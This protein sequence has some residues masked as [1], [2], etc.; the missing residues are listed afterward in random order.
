MFV[1]G[2]HAE[3]VGLAAG[4]G[5][6]GLFSV[7]ADGGE[8]LGDEFAVAKLVEGAAH[9]EGLDEFFVDEVGGNAAGEFFDRAEGAVFLAF[10]NDFVDWSVANA[11]NR[12]EAEANLLWADR[13]EFGEGFVGVG[14]EDF[15]AHFGAFFDFE[16]DAIGVAGVGA[17][18]CG[19][20]FGRIVGFEI[21]GLVGDEAVASGVGFIETVTGEWFDHFFKDFFGEFFAVAFGDCAF[22]E[23]FALFFEE[24]G[25]FFTHG[26]AED[27][28]FAE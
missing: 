14:W 24:F 22:E 12:E 18:K 15:D 21:G 19:H 20:E 7:F 28:G 9:G 10:S 6:L 23:L 2:E 5:F 26:F 27:V 3:N 16:D 4:R 1:F 13:G 17:K 11:F 8:V 25:V